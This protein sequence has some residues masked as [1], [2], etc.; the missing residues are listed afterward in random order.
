MTFDFHMHIDSQS[1]EGHVVESI[2]SRD[3]VSPE[4]AVLRI[5]REKGRPNPEQEM[6]GALSDPESIA[7]LDEVVAEAY[8]MRG[9]DQNAIL[10]GLGLFADP[11][12]AAALDGAVAM[13]YEERHRPSAQSL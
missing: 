2:I 1:P 3:H 8:R 4:E 9:Q 6:I 13:A 7:I 11:D 10:S 5:L 12:D